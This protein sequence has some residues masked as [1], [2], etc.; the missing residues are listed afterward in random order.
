MWLNT[1][2]R[3]QG[4]RPADSQNANGALNSVKTCRHQ[5]GS[6]PTDLQNASA[7]LKFVKNLLTSTRMATQGLPEHKRCAQI[8]EKL[9]GVNKS[10]P[11]GFSE[12][13][14]CVQPRDSFWMSTRIAAHIYSRCQRCAHICETLMDVNTESK[15]SAHF[16][17]ELAGR[18]ATHRSPECN[19]GAHR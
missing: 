11:V 8:C 6:Q 5:Q 12:C 15:C 14:C 18:I 13:G 3:Q 9:V 7:V 17:E 1:C 4:S 16:C 10:Q 19:R 2:R